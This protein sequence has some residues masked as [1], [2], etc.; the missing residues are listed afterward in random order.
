LK[1]GKY[2]LRGVA[3]LGRPGIALCIGAQVAIDN[4][5]DSLESAMPQ[6]RFDTT[7]LMALG[8]MDDASIVST[9]QNLEGFEPST[10]GQ[11]RQILA[12]LGREDQFFSI[13]GMDP[14][15]AATAGTSA[16]ASGAGTHSKGK[17]KKKRK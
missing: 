13:T 1:G 2:K 15:S 11:L 5:R 17:G 10:L 14:A 9:A 6:K 16:G 3:C 7:I 8:E 12:D 4:F